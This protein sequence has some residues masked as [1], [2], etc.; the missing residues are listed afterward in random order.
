MKYAIIGSGKMARAVLYDFLRDPG[1]TLIK[2]GDIDLAR[3]Q[4]MATV[5]GDERTIPSGLTHTTR[6][7]WTLFW[8]MLMYAFPRPAIP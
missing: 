1:T 3:A 4:D 8:R 2:L 7:N 5:F 6:S